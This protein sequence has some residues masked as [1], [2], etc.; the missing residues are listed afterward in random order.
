MTDEKRI[1]AEGAAMAA[2]GGTLE[3]ATDFILQHDKTVERFSKIEV[4]EEM[5]KEL[6]EAGNDCFYSCENLEYRINELK[7]GS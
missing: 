3:S 6:D 5:K 7:A 1:L 2:R 4:L